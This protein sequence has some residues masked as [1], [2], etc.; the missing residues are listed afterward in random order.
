[1]HHISKDSGDRTSAGP[2]FGRSTIS[3]HAFVWDAIFVSNQFCR[4]LRRLRGCDVA[5]ASP[6]VMYVKSMACAGDVPSVKSVHCL[7]KRYEGLCLGY[8]SG[9]I[10]YS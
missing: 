7:C 9:T 5:L 3:Q 1:M 2:F 8:L 6:M 10:K 4:L